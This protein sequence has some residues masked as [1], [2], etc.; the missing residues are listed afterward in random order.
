M[1]NPTSFFRVSELTAIIKERL[2]TDPRLAQLWVR[3]EISNFK[4]AF[5]GHL[6]FTLKDETSSVR[7]VLFKSSA[8]RISFDL[9]DGLEVFLQGRVSVFENAGALQL[10]VN[11]ALPV[12]SGELHLA[13]EQLKRKLETEG[14]FDQNRSLPILPR[15]IGIVTSATGSVLHDIINVASR[16]N[17]MVELVLA[18]ASVQGTKAPGEIAGALDLLNK[19]GGVD[20]IIAGRGGGSLEELWAF[21]TEEV[22]RAI[23]R[24]RIPVVSA[25]GHETDV[26]I[27]DFVADLR[28]P[29]PSAAAELVVPDLIGRLASCSDRMRSRRESLVQ[30]IQSGYLRID[31]LAA[32]ESLRNPGYQLE[33]RRQRLADGEKQ[34]NK[35]I[36]E[37][38]SRSRERLASDAGFLDGLSPLK[39]LAR[40]YAVVT[41]GGSVL[42]DAALCS[43]GDLL[44]IQLRNGRLEARAGRS[45]TDEDGKD[46]I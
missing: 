4:R 22:A 40:G 24:S 15:R 27:A 30:K 23:F 8:S 14:L 10:Y 7:C 2:E 45:V 11:S 32:R 42:T 18:K 35:R 31:R 5:S 44:G 28:A 36:A 26:T 6:Y 19:W 39:T 38:L 37:T 9:E 12:G 46:D 3:G 34:L 25:V 17:P 41:L 33:R 43:E 1:L 20:V 16:R 21:N 29:T 13:Y